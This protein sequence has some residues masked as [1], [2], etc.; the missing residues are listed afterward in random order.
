VISRRTPIWIEDAEGAKRTFSMSAPLAPIRRRMARIVLRKTAA[1]SADL[2]RLRR[3]QTEAS[4]LPP[5][6]IQVVPAANAWREA[7][8]QVEG[9]VSRKDALDVRLSDDLHQ[10]RAGPVVVDQN[11]LARRCRLSRVLSSL[12]PD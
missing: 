5:V 1:S 2:Q 9:A 7:K 10:A 12:R 3:R 4:P 11:N 6:C 8:G